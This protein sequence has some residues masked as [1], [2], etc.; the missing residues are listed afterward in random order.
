MAT[1]QEATPKLISDEKSC[2]LFGIAR[3][4][5]ANDG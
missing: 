2:R 3:E 4:P 1:Y 5:H